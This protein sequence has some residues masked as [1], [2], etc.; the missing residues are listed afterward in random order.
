MSDDATASHPIAVVAARTGLSRDVLR[1][2]ERRYHAVDPTRTPGGQR[3]YSDEHVHRFRLLAAATRHGRSISAVAQL[4]TEELAR[5][6]AEDAAAAP[7]TIALSDTSTERVVVAA[8]HAIRSLDAPTL[9][10][11]LRRAIAREGVPWFL[12]QFASALMLAVGDGW[13]SGQLTIAHEHL[14]SAAVI[15]ITLDTIRTVPAP[16]SAPR[17]VVATPSNERHAVGA[18][19]SAAA[20]SIDGWSIVYLGADVPCG[21]IAKAAA[22]TD[23]RAVA[24]S[25]VFVEDREAVV[26][27]IRGLRDQLDTA[28]P[29]LIGGAGVAGLARDLRLRGVILCESVAHLRSELVREA[30]SR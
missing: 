1:V 18:A 10:T 23:A 29:L 24:L 25:V 3:L 15:A 28:V 7:Q 12:E 26:S 5:M 2:W 22:E 27:E 4:G 13:A 11:L 21:D 30:Q 8:M 19:M 17:L 6:A 9:D 16:P 20:A 14:A